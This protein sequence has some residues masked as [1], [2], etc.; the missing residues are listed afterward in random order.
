MKQAL[1][2]ATV[3]SVHCSSHDQ[4]RPLELCE[5]REDVEQR[6]ALGVVVSIRSIGDRNATPQQPTI[7]QSSH[8]FSPLQ[9]TSAPA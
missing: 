9:D 5:C 8:R 6:L 1:R 4:L 3:Q 2:E 7:N